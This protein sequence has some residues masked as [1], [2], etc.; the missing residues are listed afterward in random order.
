M[1]IEKENVFLF[2]KEVLMINEC[3]CKLLYFRMFFLVNFLLLLGSFLKELKY[4][5]IKEKFYFMKLNNMYVIFVFVE[6][7][8]IVIY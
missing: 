5:I 4:V 7:M 8:C 2:F 1:V 6:N 3:Y